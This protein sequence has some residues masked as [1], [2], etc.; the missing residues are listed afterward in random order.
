MAVSQGMKD[1]LHEVARTA[2]LSDNEMDEKIII[3]F[4]GPKDCYKTGVR[5]LSYFFR[6]VY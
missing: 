3:S 6:G 2:I 1:K 4:V 5:I